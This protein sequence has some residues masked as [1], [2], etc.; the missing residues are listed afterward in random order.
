[1]KLEIALPFHYENFFTPGARPAP[2]TAAASRSQ[3]TSPMLHS[4]S[5]HAARTPHASRSP[6]A[7][8][9]DDSSN[10]YVI[11]GIPAVNSPP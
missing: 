7:C 11:T 10:S 6:W 5:L 4:F 2:A 1:M 8:R 9:P 3:A